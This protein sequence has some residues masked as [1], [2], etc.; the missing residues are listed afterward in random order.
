MEINALFGS[1]DIL[2]GTDSSEMHYLDLSG[3]VRFGSVKF[4]AGVENFLN[5]VLHLA[6]F[7]N[8]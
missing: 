1:D 8:P 7:F 6:S 5:F 2:N 4:T 3:F